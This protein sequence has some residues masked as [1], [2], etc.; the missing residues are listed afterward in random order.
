MRAMVYLFI[1]LFVM[2]PG[3][4]GPFE[5]Q[6]KMFGERK[7]EQP[8]NHAFLHDGLPQYCRP[9]AATGASREGSFV[10]RT[11][12]RGCARFLLARLGIGEVFLMSG[13]GRLTTSV[14]H[15]SIEWP[16]GIRYR[17]L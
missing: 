13:P 4:Y 17:V 15:R 16:C 10:V 11:N 5:K 14:K 3:G 2:E 12:R 6:I 8:R 9:L 7:N 1:Y